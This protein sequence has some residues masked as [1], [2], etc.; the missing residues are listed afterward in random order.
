[1]LETEVSEESE[2][3]IGAEIASFALSAALAE[4]GAGF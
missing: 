4:E 3:A 2:I 1:M